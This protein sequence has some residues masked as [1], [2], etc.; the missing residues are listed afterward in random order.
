MQ[1]D[2]EPEECTM[3]NNGVTSPNENRLDGWNADLDQWIPRTFAPKHTDNAANI[4]AL[5]NEYAST[6]P[7]TA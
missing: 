2:Q 4:A 7:K 1:A 3:P 5:E 6:I